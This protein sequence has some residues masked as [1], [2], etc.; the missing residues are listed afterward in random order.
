MP[1]QGSDQAQLLNIV[2]RAS[3]LFKP[4]SYVADLQRNSP[5]LQVVSD[6]FKKHSDNLRLWSFYETHK[7]RLGL[8]RR[9][10]VEKD[11]ATLGYDNE[12]VQLLGADH[13]GVA[14]F[15]APTDA[16]FKRVRN[17]LAST[18]TD[19]ANECQ[20]HSRLLR[21]RSHLTVVYRGD[22]HEQCQKS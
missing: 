14:R 19:V 22:Q 15:A 11:S 8:V 1:H 13:R 9:F 21:P 7:M 20:Y 18:V 16:N 5:S 2:L 12:D 17:V 3:G 6:E 10:I 4:L